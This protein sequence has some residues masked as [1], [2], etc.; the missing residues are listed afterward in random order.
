MKRIFILLSLIFCIQTTFS[1]NNTFPTSGNVGIGTISP[2]KKLEVTS[3]EV[4]V[5]IFKGT[6]G[7]AAFRFYNEISKG[8]TLSTYSSA[9]PISSGSPFNVGANGS[10]IVHDANAPF[11]IGTWG[12]AQ[13]LIFGTNSSEKMRIL[14]N[15]NVGIGTSIPSQNL[16][17]ANNNSTTLRLESTNAP[18]VYYSELTSNYDGAERLSLSTGASKLFGNKAILNNGFPQTYLNDYYGL[19]FT[20]G[21]QSPTLANVRMVIDNTGNVGIGTTTPALKFHVAGDTRLDGNLYLGGSGDGKSFLSFFVDRN[22]SNPYF[23]G[24][25][26]NNNTGWTGWKGT[27]QFIQINDNGFFDIRKAANSAAVGTNLL[28][29]VASTGNIGI[30]TDSPTQKLDVNGSA[31]LRNG[32]S[33]GGFTND[34]LLFGWN[35]TPNYL[36]SIKTRHHSGVA[37]GNAIDF[38]TWKQGTDGGGSVGT[39]HVMTLDGQGFVGIGTTAPSQKLDVRGS[40]LVGEDINDAAITLRNR[41]DGAFKNDFLIASKGDYTY[42]GNYQNNALGIYTGNQ[43]RVWIT[44]TGSVGIGTTTPTNTLD[45]NGSFRV[46]NLIEMSTNTDFIWNAYYANGGWKYRANGFAG[47]FYQ[48]GTGGLAFNIAPNGTADGTLTFQRAF[49]ILNNGNFGIGTTSPSEKLEVAGNVR[50][51]GNFNIINTTNK[52]VGFDDP[53]NYYIGYYPVTGTAGLNIHWFGGIRLGDKTGD[54]MQISDGN[55]GIGTTDTKGYKLAVGGEMIAERVVV[56]LKATWPDYVF[57][58]GYSL[59]TL[60][61]VERFVK[62][63]NHLPD[64]PSEAEVKEKGIDMEQMNATLLKKVE[65]LTLYMIELQKQNDLL[66]KR[67]DG[68]EKK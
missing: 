30:G 61:E 55:V 27:H 58:T 13:P 43:E 36:H 33:A 21:V 22:T 20:T 1:Q 45:V 39:Q 41:K 7:A 17:I 38:Y 47:G 6:S 67:M 60:S 57:K 59:R 11:A 18:T 62:T 44:G 51:N 49:T 3:P 37:S 65:E 24:F 10:I 12:W 15:G 68:L 9:Y 52:I 42:L 46:R 2:S 19:A 8:I 29:I 50:V 48:D 35:N 4:E 26:Y 14:S 56:K 31:L 53:A 64:V 63:N 5:S 28:R 16:T 34:Q 23:A 40:I 25:D 54:V 32:N 66:K